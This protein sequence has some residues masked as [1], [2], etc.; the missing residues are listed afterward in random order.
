MKYVILIICIC[1]VTSIILFQIIRRRKIR[2]LLLKLLNEFE[3][4][5][6][7]YWIDFGTL[8]GIV[9][10]Q[11][12]IIGDND[13]DVCI[14]EEDTENILK[15][16]KIVEDMRGHFFEWGAFRVY[17]CNL[18]IDIY[19]VKKGNI[20][21]SFPGEEMI[22]PKEYILPSIN[23]EVKIGNKKV[24][25]SLPQKYLELL[26]LRYGNKWNVSRYKWYTLYL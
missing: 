16:Q 19:L 5:K 25:V 12:I 8:L 7:K 1:I 2:N 14:L 26:E 11:D 4:H 20:N 23:K 15:V 10:E 18:F 6:V 17:D 9:R 24:Y 22:I 13:G 3:K 21:L